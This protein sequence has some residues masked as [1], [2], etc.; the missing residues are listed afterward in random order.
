VNHATRV[1]VAERAAR[2]G[3]RVAADAFRSDL[4][5]ETKRG[6]NDL[7]TETDRRSQRRVVEVIER[8]YPDETLI[9]EET[10]LGS[11]LPAEGAAWTVD[12][13]DGTTNYVHG[14]PL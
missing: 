4:D 7:V 8:A 3:G 9:G 2:A 1:A 14:S 10:G 13:I 11:A 12:P 6:K 5:V